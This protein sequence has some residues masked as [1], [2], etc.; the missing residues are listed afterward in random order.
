MS[1]EAEE[2]RFKWNLEAVKHECLAQ[3]KEI[4]R[5]LYESENRKKISL[6][7]LNNKSKVEWR[8]KDNRWRRRLLSNNC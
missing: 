6:K 8:R 5:S 3:S 7:W 1:Y 2:N 4:E